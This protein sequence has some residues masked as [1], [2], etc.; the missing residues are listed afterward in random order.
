MSTLTTPPSPFLPPLPPFPPFPPRMNHD[1]TPMLSTTRC[2]VT[3][4]PSTRLRAHPGNLW[5]CYYL[6]EPCMCGRVCFFTEHQKRREHFADGEHLL[7]RGRAHTRNLLRACNRVSST[8][9]LARR[10]AFLLRLA[11][12]PLAFLLLH[13]LLDFFVDGFFQRVV[14]CQIAV[15]QPLAG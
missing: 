2:D 6:C 4:L 9:T 7:R 5:M 13:S 1:Q 11:F 8:L 12:L 14:G 15:G 10:G 3:L